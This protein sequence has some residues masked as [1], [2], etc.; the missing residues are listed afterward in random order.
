M[1][2][3]LENYRRS[4]PSNLLGP[5]GGA[6]MPCCR[7]ERRWAELGSEALLPVKP[8]NPQIPRLPSKRTCRGHAKLDANDPFRKLL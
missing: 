2:P 1:A 5:G 4:S 3:A 8:D 7:R 6:L